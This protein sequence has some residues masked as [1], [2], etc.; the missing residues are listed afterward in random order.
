MSGI[1]G[2][3]PTDL[4]APEP[5][6][7]PSRRR[8]IWMVGAVGAAVVLAVVLVW[9][10]PQK[11]FIDERV[12]EAFPVAAS[13]GGASKSGGTTAPA[14]STGSTVSP[15]SGPATDED[16]GTKAPPTSSTE[17]T[18]PTGPVTLADGDFESID[19][20][21]SGKALVVDT[22]DGTRV[23]RLEDLSTDNGPDVFVY[24]S[25]A[26][27]SAG[28]KA[29]DDDFVDL[30]GLKGNLGNQN[31]EVPDDVDLDRY[32]TVVIWCR[33]FSSGFGAADLDQQ[34]AP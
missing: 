17:P 22:G 28:E 26:P 24:L 16:T 19:H 30:G 34:L 33:R 13:D 9:F 1:E 18:T 3:S 29:L 14:G 6:R 2:S 32:K 11:L 20:D 21:T 12:D 7:R 4:P 10:E 25:A 23:L 15:T 31:Y 27:V 5:E 8:R